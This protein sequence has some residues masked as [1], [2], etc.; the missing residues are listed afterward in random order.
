MPL[1]GK[2]KI[3]GSDLYF[4]FNACESANANSTNEVSLKKRDMLVFPDARSM[5]YIFEILSLQDF[6]CIRT[7]AIQLE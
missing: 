2:L 5:F 3:F 4:G 7:A 6:L 1:G